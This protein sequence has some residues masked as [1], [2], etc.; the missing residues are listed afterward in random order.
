M[1]RAVQ[2]RPK[3]EPFSVLPRRPTGSTTGPAAGTYRGA[4]EHRPS[5]TLRNLLDP[6][7]AVVFFADEAH[8][9]YSRL[10]FP[11]SGVTGGGTRPVNRAAYIMARAACLG[12]AHASVVA[13]AFGVFSPGLIAEVLHEW[14]PH[15]TTQALQR[16]RCDAGVAALHRILGPPSAEMAD[17][18]QALI[19]LVGALG[20]EGRPLFAGLQSLPFRDEPLFDLWHAADLFREHRGDSHIAAWS[21]SGLSGVEACLVNDLAQG[22]PLKSYVRTRGWGDADLEQAVESLTQRGLIADGQLSSQGRRLREQ[23]E[24]STDL[25]QTRGVGAVLHDFDQLSPVLARYRT[26]IVESGAYPDRAFVAQVTEWR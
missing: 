8:A 21:T 12:E 20:V 7:A 6:V 26:R 4:V 9:A 2:R 15:V 14:R 22:L 25:Q 11:P 13:A 23:I 3:P 24:R 16:A 5:R 19:R 10:R 17:A 18:A 1:D